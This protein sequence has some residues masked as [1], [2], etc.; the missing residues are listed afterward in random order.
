MHLVGF[1]PWVY[2]GMSVQCIRKQMNSIY[3][4]QLSYYSRCQ[5]LG[6]ISPSSLIMCL[7]PCHRQMQNQNNTDL[8]GPL[9]S[10]FFFQAYS[11][12]SLLPSSPPQIKQNMYVD[13]QI[14]YASVCTTSTFHISKCFQALVEKSHAFSQ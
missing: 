7:P 5:A 2:P 1:S 3:L 10:S 12:F 8:S 14:L 4:S 6:L 11:A 9:F 13:L